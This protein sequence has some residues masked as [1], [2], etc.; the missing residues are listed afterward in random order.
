MFV[1]CIEFLFVENKGGD[2]R[3]Q[4]RNT[5]NIVGSEGGQ[6]ISSVSPGHPRKEYSTKS[7]PMARKSLLYVGEVPRDRSYYP[8][9]ISR[10]N[11]WDYCVPNANG[12]DQLG[13]LHVVSFVLGEDQKLRF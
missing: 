4:N 12:G 13:I 10:V 8:D 11:M 1:Y 2:A 6:R 9:M 3:E 7:F 5:K